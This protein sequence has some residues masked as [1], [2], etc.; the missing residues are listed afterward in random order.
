MT[1]LVMHARSQKTKGLLALIAI[2]T[3]LYNQLRLQL[4]VVT[5][6]L[7]LSWSCLFSAGITALLFPK[8]ALML[9]LLGMLGKPHKWQDLVE[10]AA[11][12]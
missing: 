5:T 3:V 2:P 11:M 6:M 8:K 12:L 9:T 4:C 7:L 1:V 10:I